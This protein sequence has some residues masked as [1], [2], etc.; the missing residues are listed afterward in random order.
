MIIEDVGQGKFNRLNLFN[1]Q[2]G[3]Y[4]LKLFI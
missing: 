3:E 1:P 4:E 2:V